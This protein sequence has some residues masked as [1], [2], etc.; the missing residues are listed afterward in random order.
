ME[1]KPLKG[2]WINGLL[3]WPLSLSLSPRS[4]V[5]SLSLS[6]YSLS[7]SLPLSIIL[8]SVITSKSVLKK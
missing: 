7:L 3:A 2:L 5:L 6:L 4:I 1:Q 8:V